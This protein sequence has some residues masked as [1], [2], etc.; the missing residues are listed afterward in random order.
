MSE[1][2]NIKLRTKEES[3]MGHKV[4]D[5]EHAIHNIVQD[6]GFME[7]YCLRGNKKDC[8]YAVKRLQAS[9][10]ENGQTFVN[11]VVDLAIEARFL[12]VI[13]HPNIIKMRAMAATDPFAP[14]DSFFLVLDRLYDILGTRIAKWK[15]QKPKGMGK[16]LDRKGKKE[17][18]LWVE[19]IT[20]VY[21]LSCALQYLHE[22]KYA[23]FMCFNS[24]LNIVSCSHFPSPSLE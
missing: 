14:E 15:K 19:R 16:V 9:V 3:N 12:A 1:I 7:R 23:C 13:R 17:A 21:D 10:S 11:G 22:S 2:T 6:R 20:V 5:D 4:L 24:R 8:R 18:L